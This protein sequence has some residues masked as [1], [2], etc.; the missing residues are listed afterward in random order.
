[1]HSHWQQGVGNASIESTTF[2]VENDHGSNTS[3][4]QCHEGI[5]CETHEESSDKQQTYITNSCFPANNYF[6]W[7][8]SKSMINIWIRCGT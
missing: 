4:K 5:N 1:M 8:K 3:T 6:R 2:V 7:D